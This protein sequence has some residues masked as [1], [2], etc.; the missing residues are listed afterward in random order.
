MKFSQT[1]IENWPFLILFTKS[2]FFASST[3]KLVTN[4]VL[5]WMGFNFYDYDGLQPK[6]TPPKHFS[7]QCKARPCIAAFLY[8]NSNDHACI[9]FNRKIRCWHSKKNK[10]KK[11][12]GKTL[13]GSYTICQMIFLLESRKKSRPLSSRWQQWRHKKFCFVQRPAENRVCNVLLLLHTREKLLL[14]HIKQSLK[15][16]SKDE[17]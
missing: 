6:N 13:D 2:F 11:K 17:H 7:W 3:L 8:E 12:N 15:F 5:E 10:L 16:C 9:N 1:N 14:M 4:Y